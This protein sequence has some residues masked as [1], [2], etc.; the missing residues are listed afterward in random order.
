MSNPSKSNYIPYID[1]CRGMAIL[2]VVLSHAGLGNIIPGKFGVTLFFFISGFLITKLLLEER[3]GK[4]RIQMKNFY[5][6]R[7]FR[8]YPALI[9]MILTGLLFSRI[10]DCP[11]PLNDVLSALFYYTNY[12]VGWIRVPVTDCKR[13]LD[14]LWSLSVEEHFYLF[15]PLLL[16]LFL[17]NGLAKLQSFLQCLFLLCIVALLARIQLYI[18]NPTDISYVT[19]RVYF[20]THTRMDSILWGCIA[21]ILYYHLKPGWYLRILQNKKSIWFGLLLLF[22]SV[23][24]RNSFFRETFLFSFQGLGLALVIP[25]LGY[26]SI[27]PALKILESKA[28]IFIGHISYSLYLFHWIA[29]KYANSYATE[30]SFKWQLVFWPLTIIMT[31]TSYYFV[32][33]TFI[34]L[35][36]RFGSQ[37]GG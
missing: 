22:L 15:F 13:M 25:A 3:I 32:E 29:S 30:H 19:G 11:L 4:G 27:Q 10:L 35:R 7:F 23:A 36:K 5:L 2:I 37:V 21:S 1:G 12:Y 28:F 24:I 8:L 16:S 17:K 9:A 18:S 6:R 34:S 33:R 20:S 14:I 31:L 26:H